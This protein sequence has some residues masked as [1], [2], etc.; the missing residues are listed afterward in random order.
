MR[1]S[2]LTFSMALILS[3][4]ILSTHASPAPAANP[5]ARRPTGGCPR[6]DTTYKPVCASN[7]NGEEREFRNGCLLLTHNCDSPMDH[8][9]LLHKGKC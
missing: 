9:E 4:G 6:C 3:I 5:E 8:Y 1:V 7:K 2:I